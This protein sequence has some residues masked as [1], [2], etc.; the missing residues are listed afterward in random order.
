MHPPICQKFHNTLFQLCIF[1]FRQHCTLMARQAFSFLEMYVCLTLADSICIQFM[2]NYD[3]CVL[4]RILWALCGHHK[5]VQ[6][7][8]IIICLNKYL[9][10]ILACLK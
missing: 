2:G 8:K 3:L 5:Y 7:C 10:I 1:F 4:A 6:I 9:L